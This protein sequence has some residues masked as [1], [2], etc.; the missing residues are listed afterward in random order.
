MLRY[1]LPAILFPGL[2]IAHSGHGAG[3]GHIHVADNAVIDPPV[4]ALGL[5]AAVAV[6]GLRTVLR[7]RAHVRSRAGR[8]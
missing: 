5:V 3:A 1:A 2:A 7:R 4:I 8:K 6:V